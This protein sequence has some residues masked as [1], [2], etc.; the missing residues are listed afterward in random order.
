M[1]NF[2]IDRDVLTKDILIE[3]K[4]KMVSRF[5]K[6]S[7][8]V[9]ALLS[10]IVTAYAFTVKNWVLCM[11][12]FIFSVLCFLELILM[13]R[14]L[15]KKYLDMLKTRDSV[16]FS[17][18][19]KDEE[20]TIHNNALKNDEKISYEN[21]KEIKETKSAYVI[22]GKYGEVMIICKNALKDGG[23]QLFTLLK[24]KNTKIKKWPAY[25]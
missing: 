13:H 20:V 12:L 11:I 9:C 1:K 25:E 17:L 6:I 2:H 23:K 14:K 21:M 16:P 8:F 10:S 7:L 15:Y 24:S 18:V 19:F 22:I 4:N 5:P 3:V